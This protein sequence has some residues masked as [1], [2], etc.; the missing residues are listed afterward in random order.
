MSRSEQVRGEIRTRFNRVSKAIDQLVEMA[1]HEQESADVP[2]TSDKFK[3]AFEELRALRGDAKSSDPV[4]QAIRGVI[5]MVET[6]SLARD[7]PG[8]LVERKKEL[9]KQFE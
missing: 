9:Q 5:V 1:N 8:M 7:L 3:S 4:V 6:R 2:G